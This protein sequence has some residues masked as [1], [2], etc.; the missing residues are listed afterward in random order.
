MDI[1]AL[2][3]GNP[4]GLELGSWRDVYGLQLEKRR[5]RWDR[6][7]DLKGTTFLNTKD[8]MVGL[9]GELGSLGLAQ[10]ARSEFLP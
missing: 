1:F 10:I 4:I 2:K 9:D 8:V 7:T 6:R 5:H 3:G